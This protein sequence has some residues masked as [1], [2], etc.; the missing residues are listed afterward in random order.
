MK[1]RKSN[2]RQMTNACQEM[3]AGKCALM[4]VKNVVPPGPQESPEPEKETTKRIL[5]ERQ[6]E[7]VTTCGGHLLIEHAM[8]TAECDE[9]DLR[10]VKGATVPML[11]QLDEPSFGTPHS[12]A[13]DDL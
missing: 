4:I 12:Q 11:C 9:I 6:I 8:P 1:V 5:G 13:I 2:A 3:P 10:T 7:Y